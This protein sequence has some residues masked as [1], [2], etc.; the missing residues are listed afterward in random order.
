MKLKGRVWL[1]GAGPGDPGLLTVKGLQILERAE[2][3]VYDR[4]VDP[5]ILRHIP[6]NAERIDAGKQNDRHSIPQEEIEHILIEKAREGRLVV[7]L[8]GGDPFLFGRGGEEMEALMKAGIPCEPVPGVTSAIAAPASAGIPVTHRGYSSSLHVITAHRRRGGK[9]LDYATLA[10]LDGTLVFMMGVT[11]LPNICAGLIGAGMTPGT[12]AAV[13]ERGTTSRQ[14]CVR[15]SLASLAE[16]AERERVEAPAVIVVGGVAALSERLDWRAALPLCGRR[17]LAAGRPEKSGERLTALL[18]SRGAEVWEVPCIRTENLEGPLPSLSGYAWLVF[19]SPTG[20]RSLFQR[21]AAEHRDIR[22]IGGAKIAAVGPSTA[23][24]LESFGLRTDLTPSVYSGASLGES[25]LSALRL[26][27]ASPGGRLLL[28]RAQRG[29]PDLVRILKDG[30]ADYDEVPLYRTIPLKGDPSA[31]EGFG[32][33][34]AA[35]FTSASAVRSFA[36]TWPDVRLRAACIGEQTERAA[37]EAG[38]ETRVAQKATPEDLADALED[39]FT[40]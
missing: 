5:G 17:I 15:A 31:A 9:P 10:R 29:A 32:D 40:K 21:L 20:V 33:L 26:P 18:R 24:T 34:D 8:K 22:E 27:S 3:V 35:V 37:R 19:T 28:L 12:P 23:E 11:E 2:V 14:R 6:A 1:V 39:F 16:R 4:L 38:Y 7:R 25:L 36:E 30:G 13:V